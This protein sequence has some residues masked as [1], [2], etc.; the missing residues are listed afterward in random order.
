M[1]RSTEGGRISRVHMLSGDTQ[2]DTPG[3][4]A[5]EARRNPSGAQVSHQRD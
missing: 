3:V 5:E 1:K 2:P 4:G